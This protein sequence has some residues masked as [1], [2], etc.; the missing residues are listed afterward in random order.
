MADY[1][2]LPLGHP[3][4]QSPQAYGQINERL[5]APSA[6]SA[7]PQARQTSSEL[8]PSHSLLSK[9]TLDPDKGKPAKD[10][11][12]EQGDPIQRSLPSQRSIFRSVSFWWLEC[13]ACLLLVSSLIALFVTLRTQ[14]GRPLRRWSL[15][16]SINTFVAIYTIILRG[17]AAFVLSEGEN[18]G[19]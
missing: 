12:P 2:R 8:S 14:Q 18:I 6:G 10:F 13:L 1:E 4:R 16:L 11:I 5:F 17:A 7:K 9:E 3:G 19:S 15:G